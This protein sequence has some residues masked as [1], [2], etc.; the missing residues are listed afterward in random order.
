MKSWC[1][2]CPTSGL[3]G[4]N[5]GQRRDGGNHGGSNGKR[6]MY[7]AYPGIIR[8]PLTVHCWIV[9]VIDGWSIEKPL[10]QLSFGVPHPKGPRSWDEGSP[11]LGGTWN[12]EYLLHSWTILILQT[13]HLGGVT[14]T[15]I[16]GLTAS[17]EAKTSMIAL[18]IKP[19]DRSFWSLQWETT[20]R[21][22][23][24]S[25]ATEAAKGHMSKWNHTLPYVEHTLVDPNFVPS[26]DTAWSEVGPSLAW[27]CFIGHGVHV[28]R[29]APL[30]A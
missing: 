29:S 6:S 1:C 4:K 22:V 11:M 9:V 19:R 7:Q 30:C 26:R 18:H 20:A 2:C 16:W 21:Q 27:Q 25:F 8:H 13:H 15:H 24:I 23:E 5:G 14:S 28:K 10:L 12:A 3:D 17:A